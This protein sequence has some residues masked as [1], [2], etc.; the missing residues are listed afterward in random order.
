MADQISDLRLFVQLV[1]AGS[2]TQA[3]LRLN[4]SLPAMSRRLAAL[5][6]RLG[7]RLIDRG[8]RRFQLT[9]E[10]R[11]LHNRAL[12]ILM[13]VDDVEAE[14]AGHEGEPR[15]NLRVCAPVHVGREHIAPLVAEFA[16]T[17]PGMS[18][19]L[20]LSDAEV[21]V[22]EDGIDIVLNVGAPQA[23]SV[24]A[25]RVLRNR[26]V[27]CASTDYLA[28]KGAPETP[29]DLLAH[30]CILLRRGQKT[31]D[32]WKFRENGEVREVQV[33]GRLLTTSS[34]VAYQWTLTGEGI[35][36]KA[37]WDIHHDLASG[38]LVECLPQYACDDADMYI[39]YAASRHLPPRKR[40]FIDFLVAELESFYDAAQA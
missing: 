32:R 36:I 22:A 3:A 1:E 35:G 24:V 6:N 25:R 17:H 29:D 27:V 11:I 33:R 20:V 31:L 4:S 38:R 9:D 8:T 34:E 40:A 5:E 10:G 39:V 13:A 7:A 21:D 23:Q 16:R 2:L 14:V 28:R 18:I 12:E 19:E 37:L 30:E 15:G 26:R